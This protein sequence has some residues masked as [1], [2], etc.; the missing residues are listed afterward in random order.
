MSTIGDL[1]LNIVVKVVEQQ[2]GTKQMTATLKD[3][4]NVVGG[5]SQSMQTLSSKTASAGFVLMAFRE[6]ASVLSSTIGGVSRAIQ[7]ASNAHQQM[8]SS[9]MQLDA[10][11]KLTGQSLSFLQ[12]TAAG[13]KEEFQ[14]S[15]PSANKFTVEISK[16]T[17]KAGE[18]DKTSDA[19]RSLIN[20][21]AAQGMSTEETLT[22]VKQAV[23]GI[24]EGT[25][26]L[27]A[28]NPSVLYQEYASKM[29]LAVGKMTDQQKA[30]AL[31][32]SL[33]E[34][35]GK[36]QGKY[37]EYLNTTAGK[38]E[39]LNIKITEAKAKLGEQLQPVML[40]LIDTV[41]NLLNAFNKL[42]PAWQT[43]I[44]G[45]GTL[46]LTVVRLL[47]LMSQLK[48]VV[49]ELGPAAEVGFGNLKNAGVKNIGILMGKIGLLIAL[50]YTLKNLLDSINEE[51]A[52]IQ[53]RTH[54]VIDEAG[55][56]EIDV[57]KGDNLGG[58]D[59]SLQGYFKDRSVTEEAQK[60]KEAWKEVLV[61]P[62]KKAQELA[63]KE[64]EKFQTEIGNILDKTGG[65]GDGP[66]GKSGPV[67]TYLQQLNA[68]MNGLINKAASQS[69]GE[70]FAEGLYQR[71]KE[72][73]A[74]IESVNA[75][76]SG[77]IDYINTRSVAAT[78]EDTTRRTTIAETATDDLLS[79]Q[80]EIEQ[81]RKDKEDAAKSQQRSEAALQQSLS[82]ASQIS[83]VLGIGADTFVGT[84]LSGLQEG[85]SLANS[86]ASLLNLIL[87]AGSGGIFSLLGFAGGGHVPGSG[88]GDTV[89]AML[90]PGEYVI[91]KS[92]VSKLGTGFFEWLNGGGLLSSIAGKYAAGGLVQQHNAAAP[93]VY[94]INSKIKGNDLELSLKRTNR[95]NNRRLT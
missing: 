69:V 54:Q 3:A 70:N 38:Q 67:L 94:L 45:G 44:A 15:T 39:Q 25:D 5:F 24:D 90:T 76:N 22:A 27:F 10:A 6:A 50:I 65:S 11:S 68:E 95:I 79:F 64:A 61:D 58:S 7:D 87:G 92:V 47:P 85:L 36:V 14:L 82:F 84:L 86:F 9:Q 62:Q 35:G 29:G 59:A 88:S 75:V 31:L 12:S 57:P 52:V 49:G 23:L 40:R 77:F 78:V 28:K 18:I 48:N 32:S 74:E 2:P 37:S 4:K 89:P 83:S 46:A 17:Q 16:L 30:Q 73:R 60:Q 8:L 34:A 63:K 13:A 72:L 93:Q 26:K 43:V 53:N 55:T 71:I 41:G 91:R 21:G 81:R 51:A 19:I 66:G 20:L 1:E 42:S 80:V 33:V 56:K